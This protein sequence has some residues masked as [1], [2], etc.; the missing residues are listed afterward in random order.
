MNRDNTKLSVLQKKKRKSS[1]ADMNSAFTVK[2]IVQKIF[3]FYEGFSVRFY[4]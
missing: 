3:K 1:G 2:N 4:I